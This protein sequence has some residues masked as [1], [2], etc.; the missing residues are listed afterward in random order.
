MRRFSLFAPLLIAAALLHASALHA[1]QHNSRL[2][3]EALMVHEAARQL[4]SAESTE[5]AHHWL[6]S[7]S[8]IARRY[9][10]DPLLR[11]RILSTAHYHATLNQLPPELVLSVIA[12]E[13]SFNPL[14]TSKVGARGLMQVMPFWREELGTGSDNLYDIEVNIR[15]GCQILKRYLEREDGN[16]HRALARYNGSL[17]SSRYPLKVLRRW[18]GFD[19]DLYEAHPLLLAQR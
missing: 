19:D 13:S 3:L 15:Y 12:V 17:G 6:L 4:H 8:E 18:H 10:H 1:E 5:A 16:L 14:A 7:N 9:V 2:S 11:L